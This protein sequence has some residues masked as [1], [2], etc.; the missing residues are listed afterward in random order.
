MKK[1]T[2]MIAMI[3]LIAATFGACGKENVQ[4]SDELYRHAIEDAVFA[5]E[6]EIM[7]LVTLTPDDDRVTWDDKGRVLLLTFHRYPDSYPTG[8]T[9][10]LEWGEVW[11]FTEKEMASQYAAEI[12]HDN[13]YDAALKHLLG[14]PLDKE[15]TTVT[16]FWVYPKDIIRP[17]YQT[18]PT[19]KS[20]KVAFEEAPDSEYKEWFDDN[21]LS[22]YF[23]GDY[24][25]TRLGYTYN[26]GNHDSE[27]GVT[28]FLVKS[29]AQVEVEFTETEEEFIDRLEAI[30]NP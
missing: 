24:P 10:T 9:V 26:W 1:K 8:E 3:T 28:E 18:D 20:M 6:D 17:A 12:S 15:N 2:L 19:D 7:D 13:D 30:Q 5:D 21:I 27:Y 4:D 23:Y 29:G 11:T 14:M 22:S 25:W 16:G